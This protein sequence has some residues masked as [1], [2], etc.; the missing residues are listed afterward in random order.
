MLIVNGDWEARHVVRLLG[1]NANSHVGNWTKI[2]LKPVTR[3]NFACRCPLKQVRCGR[4]I[5]LATAPVLIVRVLFPTA[6]QDKL[7]LKNENEMSRYVPVDRLD[8]LARI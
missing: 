4:Q 5:S 7:S 1:T 3:V 2:G 6:A 8:I